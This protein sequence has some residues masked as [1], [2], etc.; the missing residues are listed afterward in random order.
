MTYYRK[1]NNQK[2]CVGLSMFVVAV[3]SSGE[4][5]GLGESDFEYRCIVQFFV[6]LLCCNVETESIQKPIR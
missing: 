3:K 5:T 1:V 6:P 4:D 2:N